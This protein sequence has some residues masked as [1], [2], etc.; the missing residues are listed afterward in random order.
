[1]HAFKMGSLSNHNEL[2]TVFQVDESGD[3]SREKD[4]MCMDKTLLSSQ[5]RH[6]QARPYMK[7]DR[8]KITR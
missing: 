8:T 6:Q 5:T 1:M 3:H 4:L 2:I 7:T